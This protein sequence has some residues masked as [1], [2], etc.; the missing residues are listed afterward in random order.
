MYVCFVFVIFAFAY[1]FASLCIYLSLSIH[2]DICINK[3]KK[4]YIYIY[5]YIFKYLP[6][7]DEQECFCFGLD[8]EWKPCCPEHFPE[9]REAVDVSG[10]RV[11]SGPLI[12]VL[13]RDPRPLGSPER[14]T[15]AHILGPN[16][17]VSYI[18][19]PDGLGF[20]VEPKRLEQS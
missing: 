4:K 9:V 12:T 18:L 3:F 17:G 7:C 11:D 15:V 14:L 1:A 20:A 6:A 2:K 8:A 13:I 5:I 16:I 10:A 19:G